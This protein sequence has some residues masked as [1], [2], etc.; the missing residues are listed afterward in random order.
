[1][2]ALTFSANELEGFVSRLLWPLFR[3]MGFFLAAPLIGTQL[4]PA[5]VRIVLAVAIALLLVPILPPGPQLSGLSLATVLVIMHQL[6]IGVALGFFL[7]LLFQLF[8]LMGQ[9]IAMQMGLGFASMIDPSNGINVAIMS[10]FY[11]MFVS[12]LFILFDGHLV[13][14]E[15]LVDSFT[16]IPVA[17]VS[18]G[19]AVLMQIVQT[20]GWVF[21]SAMML[22][23]PALTALLVTNFS[24]GIMTRAAPQLNIFALGFPIALMFGLFIVWISMSVFLEAAEGLF[25]DVFIMMRSLIGQ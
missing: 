14:I 19:P 5:R 4:V 13:M 21:S 9:M 22:S 11:L 6:L 17:E 2:E 24:F 12:L 18:L 16:S 20:I 23:L 1:M 25:A 8:V 15:V 3:I 10:S 7:Q